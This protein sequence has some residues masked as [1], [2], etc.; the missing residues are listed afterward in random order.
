MR[1]VEVESKSCF[2]DDNQPD[3]ARDNYFTCNYCA[4]A[5]VFPKRSLED[6]CF[7]IGMSKAS[8]ARLKEEER[9][10]I[11][12]FVEAFLASE[13]HLLDLFIVV[14][15]HC[16]KCRAAFVVGFS[17]AAHAQGFL[18]G[19]KALKVWAVLT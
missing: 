10:V 6:Q 4:E 17:C 13:Q 1:V 9:T 3:S 11:L 16:P 19:Y 12:P 15:F 18:L 2:M 7:G 14:D 5:V 8:L